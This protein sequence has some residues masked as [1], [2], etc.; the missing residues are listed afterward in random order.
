MIG[1]QKILC[2][3]DFSECSQEA[4]VYALHLRELAH[5]HLIIIS[6]VDGNTYDLRLL[7]NEPESSR[8][9]LK[10]DQEMLDEIKLRL[11]EKVPLELRDEVN[12]LVRFGIPDVEIVKT[13][14]ERDINLIVMGT[15]ARSGI[16]HF[17]VGSVAEKVSRKAPCPV[18]TVKV[19]QIQI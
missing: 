16:L 3:V 18:M 12:V 13:A 2:P 19:P 4:L 5:S 15:H 11:M 7:A 17:L 10:T 9:T 6:I 8:P 14:M 1:F